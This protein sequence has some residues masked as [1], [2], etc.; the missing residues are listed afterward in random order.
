MRNS[1]SLSYGFFRAG[2]TM[3]EK[4]WPLHK[5][6]DCKDEAVLLQLIQSPIAGMALE[7]AK[8]PHATGRILERLADNSSLVVRHEVAKNPNT[9]REILKNMIRDADMLIH[10]YARQTLAKLNSA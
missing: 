8:S 5:V 9:P 1:K 4:K 6:R 2:T 3:N 10:S 7:M